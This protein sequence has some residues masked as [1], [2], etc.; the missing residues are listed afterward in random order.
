MNEFLKNERWLKGPSFLHRIENHWPE[1]KFEKVEEKLEI[2]KEVYLTTVHPRA[3]LNCLLFRYSS[4]NTLLRTFAWILKF[5]QWL[6]WSAK[7]KETNRNEITRNIS[8]EEIKK[9]KREVV[10]M[11][12]KETFPQ[13]LK[14]LEAGR[15]VKASSNIVKLKPMIKNDGVLRV[16][17]RIA[18]APISPDIMNPMILP[19]NHHVST[20][21][22]RY[23]HE[24]NGHCGVE[25]VLSLL[26]EQFWVIKGRAAVKEVIGRCISCKKRMAPR[27]T[28]EMAELAKIRLTPYESPFTYSGVDYFGPFQVKRGRGKV[29]GK[30]W[31]AIFVCMNSRAVHLE[32]AKSLETDDF[33]LLLMRFLN[34]RG[35]VKELRSDNG[36]NFVGANR[37]IKEAIEHIDDGKVRS[38]LLQHG[39]KWVF[40]PPGASHMSGVWERLV[41]S[42]KRSLKAI[43]GKDLINEEVLQ[44]VFTE[45][46]RIANSR[47]LTRTSSSPEDDEPLTPSHFLN[48]RPTV[49][50]PSEMVDESDRFSRKR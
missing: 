39:C 23:V 5:L 8:H 19:R 49:N 18:R 17:G 24:R 35:H 36:T 29:A 22:I 11:V 14:D 37:E 28:Q 13:E 47:P 50:L 42:V 26:R 44:T 7:K 15:Q 2:K 31:G 3:P 25:Q 12:Q 45:A 27:M 38:E 9:A 43:I 16:G 33:I 1:T 34:R 21:L 20:I 48:I 10:A 40:Y 46:E 30:R 41:K 4:W 32:V 6:K